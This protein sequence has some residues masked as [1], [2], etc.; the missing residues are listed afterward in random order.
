[1]PA[2]G[3]EVLQPVKSSAEPTLSARW[4]G[5]DCF[6]I[7]EAGQILGLSRPAAY[8]AAKRGELPCFWI[9]RRGIVPRKPLE[10]LLNSV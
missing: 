8:A 7:P 1:M 9:G 6:T 10:R 4:A 5:R 3:A 2:Q